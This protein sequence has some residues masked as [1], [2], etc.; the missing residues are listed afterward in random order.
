MALQGPPGVRSPR[1]QQILSLDRSLRTFPRRVAIFSQRP[2]HSHLAAG[3]VPFQ[4]ASSHS[5]CDHELQSVLASQERNSA[6]NIENAWI[7]TPSETAPV[8]GASAAEAAKRNAPQQRT[9]MAESATKAAEAAVAAAANAAA[10][11][12]A[13]QSKATKAQNEVTAA[14]EKLQSAEASLAAA[15]RDASVQVACAEPIRLARAAQAVEQALLSAVVARQQKSETERSAA[16]AES[17]ARAAVAVAMDTAK[18]AKLMSLAEV[19]A[20]R[21]AARQFPPPPPPPPKMLARRLS[22]QLRATSPDT[23]QGSSTPP[24]SSPAPEFEHSD[25][26]SDL[27]ELPAEFRSG[28]DDL[29]PDELPEEWNIA[30]CTPPPP[31]PRSRRAS[32]DQ[33]AVSA[34]SEQSSAIGGEARRPAAVAPEAPAWARLRQVSLSQGLLSAEV[35]TRRCSQRKPLPPGLPPALPQPRSSPHDPTLSEAG[36]ISGEEEEEEENAGVSLQLVCHG[37]G[38]PLHALEISAPMLLGTR[39]VVEGSESPSPPSS[40][41]GAA[42]SEDAP[43]PPIRTPKAAGIDSCRTQQTVRIRGELPKGA[44]ALAAE[45]TSKMKAMARA[46]A[47]ADGETDFWAVA[48]E[49]QAVAAAAEATAQAKQEAVI[50]PAAGLAKAKAPDAGATVTAA[51]GTAVAVAAPPTP[52][53]V[54]I[55]AAPGLQISVGRLPAVRNGPPEA[56]TPQTPPEPMTSLSP[57]ADITPNRRSRTRF[58]GSRDGVSPM[59]RWLQQA[60]ERSRDKGTAQR[61]WLAEAEERAV[62]ADTALET[63]DAESERESAQRPV[64]VRSSGFR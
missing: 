30:A 32:F 7:Q 27:D 18:A 51:T 36:E 62:R 8:P 25:S 26:G 5:E 59:Q 4:K 23:V 3:Q 31:P 13:F 37:V 19:E 42:S 58:A 24:T 33:Q 21:S 28:P 35:G 53:L 38:T 46:W 14:R 2:C 1:G 57:D 49:A 34:D 61:A 6:R 60:E 47:E 39:S 22:A 54:A 29:G 50:F 17:A 9:E 43:T 56:P 10:R 63:R 20:C 11:A 16:E 48:A 52:A 15:R 44:A 55:P 45:T 64:R 41:S 12:S 40:G